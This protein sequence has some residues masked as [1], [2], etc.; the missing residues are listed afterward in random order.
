V[1]PIAEVKD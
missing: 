1:Y